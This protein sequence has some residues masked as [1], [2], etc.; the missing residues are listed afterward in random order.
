MTKTPLQNPFDIAVVIPTI[1]RAGLLK[2]VQS[3]YEQDFKGRIQILLGIDKPLGDKNIIHEIMSACPDNMTITVFD[4]GYSTS[5]RHGGIYSNRFG[6]ALRTILTYA[7]N[8]RYVAYLDDDNW[9]APHHVSDM[10]KAVHGKAWAYSLR[11]FVDRNTNEIICVDDY[12]SVGPGK[13][14]FAKNYG[15]FVDT[16]CLILDKM[17]C[18]MIIPLWCIAVLPDGSGEDRRVFNALNKQFSFQSTGRPSVYYVLDTDKY[19]E[20]TEWL[21]N[22]GYT[23]T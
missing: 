12:F 4:P 19:S 13:G 3:I 18:H 6:G 11:W 5:V 22:K 15:G 17:Q 21:R 8:S 7:A 14:V 16:N 2:A 1:L 23:I 10:L 9:Y 20:A